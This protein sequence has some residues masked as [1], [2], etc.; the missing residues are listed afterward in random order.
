MADHVERALSALVIATGGGGPIRSERPKSIHVLC[1][2]PMVGYVIDALAQVAVTSAVVITGPSSN[3]VRAR[4][5][6]HQTPVELSFVEQRYDRGSGDAAL[7]GLSGFDDFLDDADLLIVPADLPLIDP[8]DLRLLLSEHRASGAACTALTVPADD[9]DHLVVARDRHGRV[10]GLQPQAAVADE[11]ELEA[12]VGVYCV[13]RGLL[14]PA[15]R[16]AP[17]AGPDGRQDLHAVLAVLAESGHRVA[18]VRVERSPSLSPVDSRRE[19]AQAEAELRRRI[20]GVWLDR[21]VSMVDPDRTY[22]DTTVTLGADVTLFPGT[23]LQ[24]HT[25]IGDGCEIGPDTRLDDCEVGADTV[26]EKTMAR[27]ARVGDGCRVGPFAVLEPGSQIENGTVTGP[28]YAA[29]A[30]DPTAETG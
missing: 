4:M 20:N 9:G 18:T 11:T 30:E 29:T 2:Q 25:T 14:A 13:S 19:L 28:F 7:V 21:G 10:T 16:R 12:V 5:L 23:L 8:A 6:D 3:R 22:V 17:L 26:I 1:G 24:G 27:R 15:V